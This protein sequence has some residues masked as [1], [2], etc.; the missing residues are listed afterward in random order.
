LR[1]CIHCRSHRKLTCS[2]SL[3]A[4]EVFQWIALVFTAAAS[5]SASTPGADPLDGKYA[6]NL[7]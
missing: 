4:G 5:I 6:R 1:A 7:G 3:D 2:S